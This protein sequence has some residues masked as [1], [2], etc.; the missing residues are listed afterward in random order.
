MWLSG[1]SWFRDQDLYV[2]HQQIITLHFALAH[3]VTIGSVLFYFI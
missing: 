3:H 1:L 2:T